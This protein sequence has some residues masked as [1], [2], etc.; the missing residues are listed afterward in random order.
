MSETIMLP[1]LTV[2]L[3]DWEDQAEHVRSVA[4]NTGRGDGR[5]RR[6][7]GD[8]VSPDV[9]MLMEGLAFWMEE[10]ERLINEGPLIVATLPQSR[11]LQRAAGIGTKALDE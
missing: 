5:S 2:S 9:G 6:L 3:P 1:I 4:N 11:E 8:F 10:M 7:P